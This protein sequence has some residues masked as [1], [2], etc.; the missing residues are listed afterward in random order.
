VKY[1]IL[2]VG[3]GGQGTLFASK[4]LSS[5]AIAIGLNV[6][7]T[8]TVG[9]AQRGGSVTSHVRIS[10]SEIYS[11]LVPSGHADF[12]LG[13]EAIEMLRHK[14]VANKNTVYIL[15]MHKVPTTYT[16]MG[17]DKYPRDQEIIKA[18][19]RIMD[20]GYVIRASETAEKLGFPQSANMVMVGALCKVE[21]F[22]SKERIREQIKAVAPRFA[23]ANL[24]AFDAGYDLI[25]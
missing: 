15:N 14:Q 1:D 7:S 19:K 12:L 23:A 16:M 10:D 24:K 11:P 4:V 18:A 3:V 21:P 9:A 2:I 20:K 25:E 6:L 13:F 22:F 17:I 5:Y 8:D